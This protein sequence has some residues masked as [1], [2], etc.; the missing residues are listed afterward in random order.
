MKEINIICPICKS[1]LK[2]DSKTAL[3]HNG[4]SFDR[5][6]SG[7]LNLLLNHK[8]SGDNELM[9]NARNNILEKGYFKP[10]LDKIIA[11]LKTYNLDSILDVGSG[12]GYYSRHIY[13]SLKV[14]VYG[15]DISKYACLKASKLSKDV[16]YIVASNYDMP[17]NDNAFDAT[18]NIFAP[19]SPELMRISRKLILKVVPNSYHLWELKELLYDDAHIR[20]ANE[21]AF[22]DCYKRDEILLNYQVKVDKLDDL[23]KM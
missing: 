19:H 10:L 22:I 17:F 7:Y 9:I 5:A 20:T 3:C 8:Q 23:I 13:E 1:D 14:P 16:M 15:I 21:S 6:K 11:I 18:V 4:H 12:E 2:L